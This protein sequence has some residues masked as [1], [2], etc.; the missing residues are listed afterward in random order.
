MRKWLVTLAVGVFVS[1]GFILAGHQ[2]A[3]TQ[4][5][6]PSF[7]LK[8]QASWTSAIRHFE[9]FDRI[10]V[11][12]VAKLSDNVSEPISVLRAIAADNDYFVNF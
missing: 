3:A 2:P 11:D 6:P 10:F 5:Q 8:V 9:G 1:C 12:R 7:V 4:A